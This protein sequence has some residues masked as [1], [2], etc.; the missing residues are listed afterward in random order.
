M[1]S[2]RGS[3]TLFVLIAMIFFL[4]IAFTAYASASSKLQGQNGELDRIKANYGQDLTEEGLASL[5][6]KLTAPVGKSA[7]EL[8]SD[9]AK[10]KM[11]IGDYVDYTAGKWSNTVTTP[12]Q[13]GQ[14][15]G[16]V[17]DSN[18]EQNVQEK[19]SED[20]PFYS[21][22][23]IWNINGNTV[24][25]ISAGCPEKYYHELGKA[26]ASETI[27]TNTR[28]WNND[29]VDSNKHGISARVLT[30]T[31]VDAWYKANI[32]SSITDTNNIQWPALNEENKKIVLLD[33]NNNYYLASSFN[34]NALWG[35]SS[36]N[37]MTMS[38]EG[39]IAMGIRVIVTLDSNTLFNEKPTNIVEEGCKFNI[40]N[41]L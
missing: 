30:K 5:Y 33:N 40:W 3:I 18:K 22:W 34:S 15:G 29:Y 35:E 8:T 10:V 12:A 21:G 1:K 7:S 14:F 24:T 25:L 6:E 39:N 23:R 4:T 32:N 31:D 13:Q 9:N 19:N 26:V 28:N 36:S 27:L 41:I 17:A 11:Q 38:T 37:H 16:Y 2:E 20:R